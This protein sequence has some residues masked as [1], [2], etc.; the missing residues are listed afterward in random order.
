MRARLNLDLGQLTVS[1][2]GDAGAISTA[3]FSTVLGASA[4]GLIV[5]AFN[6]VSP[7]GGKWSFVLSLNGVLAGMV[8]QV[9]GHSGHQ[10]QRK[11]S[12][13]FISKYGTTDKRYQNSRIL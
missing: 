5:L 8:A 2:D 4:G 11:H 13:S 6:K 12:V 3:V 1:A 7:S 9:R 10:M